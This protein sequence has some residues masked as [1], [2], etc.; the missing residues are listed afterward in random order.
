LSVAPHS[1]NYLTVPPKPPL[2]RDVA[3]SLRTN[4]TEAEQ[5]LWSR[6]RR[7]QIRGLKFR[8]QFSIGPFYADFV[9]LNARLV[10]ELDGSQHADQTVRDN[11]RSKFLQD[12]GYTVLRFWNHEIF[13]E[14][15]EVVQRI[16]NALEAVPRKIKRKRL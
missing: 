1:A 13:G 11:N 7:K 2:S 8:R 14:I 10:I 12:A 9:C 15:D 3:R 6:L 4:Q 16:A 5:K